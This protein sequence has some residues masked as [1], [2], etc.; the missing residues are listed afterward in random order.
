MTAY[1]LLTSCIVK[2]KSFPMLLS[3]W[4]LAFKA[5]I[6]YVAF[7]L[8]SVLS[9]FFVIWNN[10]HP[11]CHSFGAWR[12]WF[13]HI[14]LWFWSVCHLGLH[15]SEYLTGFGDF[16]STW[17]SQ[18]S[19]GWRPQFLNAVLC[20]CARCL[21]DVW[22]RVFRTWCVTFNREIALREEEEEVMITS[23]L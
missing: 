14:I 20:T 8:S 3:F 12:F 13:C 16:L 17:L 10:K 2:Q 19:L 15:Y 18:M 22:L 7:W 9:S 11:F 23:V 21:Q 5:S 6:F 1:K 4:V